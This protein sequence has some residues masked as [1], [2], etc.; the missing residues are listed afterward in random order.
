MSVSKKRKSIFAALHRHVE[1]RPF[2]IIPLFPVYISVFL[3]VSFLLFLFVVMPVLYN[4]HDVPE[5]VIKT[6]I[7]ITV[8]VAMM[9]L[10]VALGHY[11]LL[12]YR[13]NKTSIS[14]SPGIKQ[15]KL[16]LQTLA[17]SIFCFSVVHYCIHLF[18]TEGAYS[19]I[20]AIESLKGRTIDEMIDLWEYLTYL[21]NPGMIVDFVYFSTAT[22]VTVGY[23]DIRPVTAL[24]KIFTII[25]MAYGFVMIVVFLGIAIGKVNDDVQ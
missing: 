8:F 12:L 17:T 13:A 1:K 23:G 21:P 4:G 5:S 24:A 11:C 9:F 14:A 16:I 2:L 19:E 6:R 7:N 10:I 20:L 18:S 15:L 22:I 25:E 3:A